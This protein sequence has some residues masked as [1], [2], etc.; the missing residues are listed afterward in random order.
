MKSLLWQFAIFFS[1]FSISNAQEAV[2]FKTQKAFYIYGDAVAIG[3]N[4]LSKDSKK[5]YNDILLTNDDIDMVYV[6]IDQD[7]ST[8]SS[9]SA[10]LQLPDNQK[11]IAYAILYWSATYSYIKGS[12]REENSQFYFQGDRQRNR[13]LINKI[14]LKLPGESYQDIKG[15]VL[16]DGAT[17]SS[18]ALNAPYV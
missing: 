11:E 16:F 14:K 12:R 7:N 8:F 17:Q 2:R 18:F 1:F 6:D 9:S 4:I 5:P 3:N 13:S 15:K 10:N